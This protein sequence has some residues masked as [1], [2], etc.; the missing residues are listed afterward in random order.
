MSKGIKPD[1][2]LHLKHLWNVTDSSLLMLLN[3]WHCD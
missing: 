2:N 3:I 1:L